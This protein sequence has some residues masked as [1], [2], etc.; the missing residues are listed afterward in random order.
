MAGG[1]RPGQEA[2]KRCCSRMDDGPCRLCPSLGNLPRPP[3]VPVPGE[4]LVRKQAACVAPAW[5]SWQV[6]AV[7]H[8]C[9][10]ARTAAEAG[11]HRK[12]S[13]A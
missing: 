1:E 5:P 13:D 9:G 3:A 12:R 10:L 11:I 4:P 7:R 2:D 8:P 6:H